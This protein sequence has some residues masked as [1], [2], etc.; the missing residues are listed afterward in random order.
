[1]TMETKPAAKLTTPPQEDA[2]D[3]VDDLPAMENDCGDV[4]MSDPP[5]PSSPIAQAVGRK[6]Q[7]HSKEE[8][9]DEDEDAVEVAQPTIHPVVAAQ[10]V[11]IAG[12]RPVPKTKKLQYPTPENSS[13][14]RPPAENVDPSAWSEVTNKLNVIG[15]T[16]STE[17]AATGKLQAQ[18]TVEEDGSLRFFWIDYTELN[19]SLLLFGKVRNKNNGRFSS[20]FVKVDN[21]MRKL[22]F[23]PREH[24][25]RNGRDTDE[26]VDMAD[27]YEEVS[28][29]MS[30]V[31]NRA[32][33]RY[34]IKPCLRKYAFEISDVPR[35][36]DY[37][38]LLYSYEK[39]PLPM[40]TTGE[41]FSH[42]FGS[43]TSLFEQFVLWKN[44]MGPCWLKIE[45]ADFNAVNN[46][47]WCKLELQVSQPNS[48]STLGDSDN[49]EA[50]PL[51]IMSI[52]LRTTMNVK[53]N[54]QEILVASARI[55][56]D[57]SLTDT[58][59][60]HKLPCRTLTVMRPIEEGYPTGFKIDIENHK[61]TLKLERSEQGLLSLFLA[62]LQRIDPDVL[63]GHRLED[64]DYSLLLSR[65]RD[66]KIPGWH[67]I[68]R[69]R[70][71]AWPG[72]MGKGGGS[73][74][75][76]RQI[77]TGRLLVDLAN[78]MGKVKE[79]F[80][81]RRMNFAYSILPVSHDQMPIMG[82]VRDV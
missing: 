37:L 43:N 80:L 52:A 74:F 40:E 32:Q 50:P 46:A 56:E 45:E 1:M 58:T 21:V 59:L 55:Y 53:D 15:S 14:T 63:V 31:T 75:A 20:C 81:L 28:N 4:A 10:S 78:D 24:R 26:E 82:S 27:V 18:D 44:I 76:E 49:L 12:S 61:G 60:P 22:F 16:T 73:F 5:A 42:V 29:L 67:R 9:E 6:A 23:L 34:K 3:D 13:P 35:E 19:G 71:S 38:K 64:L 54:K 17:T 77:V 62:H 68:G 65:L 57:L 33:D 7:I 69:L 47:S 48:I 25:L 30:K 72:N 41:T 79:H 11:N 36:A 66:K 8:D 70:R 39:P 2:L 51:T